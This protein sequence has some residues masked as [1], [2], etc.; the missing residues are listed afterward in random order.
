MD[1]HTPNPTK[2]S[3]SYLHSHHP[4]LSPPPTYSPTSTLT[5]RPSL[6]LIH[7]IPPTPTSTLTLT[8]SLLFPVNCTPTPSHLFTTHISVFSHWQLCPLIFLSTHIYTNSLFHT[9]T[10][11]SLPSNTHTS[12][13]SRLHPRI[14]AMTLVLFQKAH[15]SLLLFD[16]PLLTACQ[17]VYR[18]HIIYRHWYNW[19][20][21]LNLCLLL[22]SFT[23]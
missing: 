8:F 14:V 18:Q 6:P 15:A 2:Q 5:H 1:P 3:D 7:T 10:L 11:A 21:L 22:V 17:I 19:F 4:L 9:L 16:S 13:D 23:F 12:T 20:S